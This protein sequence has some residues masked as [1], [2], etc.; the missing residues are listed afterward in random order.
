[1]TTGRVPVAATAGTHETGDAGITV[2]VSM[3]MII[4]SN[5]VPTLLHGLRREDVVQVFSVIVVCPLSHNFVHRIVHLAIVI[6]Q[7]GMMEDAHAVVQHLVNRHIWVVP[8]VDN[9]WCDVLQDC[10]SNLSSRLIEN[11]GEVVLGEHTVSG[12]GGVR[13]SPDLKLMLRC[14]V[15]DSRRAALELSRC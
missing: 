3:R 9:T 2:P 1:M 13:I 8:S 10:H 4:A 11:V 5:V 6:S 15:N 7:R 12:V 14:R